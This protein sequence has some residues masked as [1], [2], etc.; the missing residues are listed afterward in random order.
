VDT[1]ALDTPYAD[2]GIRYSPAPIKIGLSFGTPR[3]SS[4]ASSATL[5]T[6]ERVT[7]ATGTQ[8]SGRAAGAGML[9]ARLGHEDSA[10]T[11]DRID[12]AT[13][14]V[15]PLS[16]VA[17]QGMW[18]GR[19]T[20]PAAPFRWKRTPVNV[21]RDLAACIGQLLSALTMSSRDMALEGGIRRPSSRRAGRGRLTL[22]G[23]TTAGG[24]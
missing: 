23:R 6:G 13:N 8:R 17:G 3:K 19:C 11:M 20:P 22:R 16:P 7:I 2:F 15:L 4:T 1:E 14:E 24:E 18:T 12:P 9:I 21:R 10:G 5:A